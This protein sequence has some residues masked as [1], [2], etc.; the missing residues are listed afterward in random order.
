MKRF[1]L[2]V[3]GLAM[4]LTAV[5]CTAKKDEA[6]STAPTTEPTEELTE[7]PTEEIEQ[8]LTN[9]EVKIAEHVDDIFR[10]LGR[11]Y[12]KDNVLKL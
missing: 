5:S 9:T 4:I 1:L 11:T 7:A 3:L 6:A 2:I 8:P 12:V 10:Q